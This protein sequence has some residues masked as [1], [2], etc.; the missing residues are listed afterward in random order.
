MKTVNIFVI[1]PI[2]ESIAHSY[3][4]RTQHVYSSYNEDFTLHVFDCFA[5]SYYINN[6]HL[7]SNCRSL[8][9]DQYFKTFIVKICLNVP[10][11]KY[12][13]NSNPFEYLLTNSFAS[14]ILSS[15]GSLS[16][17]PVNRLSCR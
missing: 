12:V 2:V 9:L 6:P 3:Q 14:D 11:L 5:I 13:P 16:C 10:T 4:K 1:D 8:P 7:F 17:C 15:M